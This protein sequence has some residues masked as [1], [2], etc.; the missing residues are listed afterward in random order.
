[1]MKRIAQEIE[2]K[3]GIEDPEEM[4]FTTEYGLAAARAACKVANEIKAKLICAFTQ[5]G[6]TAAR[7]SNFR[8]KAPII[9]FTPSEIT[10]RRL[11]LM[12]GVTPL[13]ADFVK[14]F[15]EVLEVMDKRISECGMAEPDDPV[16]VVYGYPIMA[17]G[18]TNSIHIHQVGRSKL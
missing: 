5:S 15:K 10:A 4:I 16:V 14:D 7:I 12:W 1:M 3:S 11:A 9:A 8:P 17:R 18:I 13:V 2:T 6:F